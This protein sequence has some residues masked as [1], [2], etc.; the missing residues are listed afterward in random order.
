[1]QLPLQRHLQWCALVSKGFSIFESLV[2]LNKA[3]VS[4]MQA[5]LSR[6]QEVVGGVTI[7]LGKN[8]GQEPRLSRQ[9]TC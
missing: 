5:L 9:A 8:V 1:M 6:N 2:E 7:L 4:G 3:R